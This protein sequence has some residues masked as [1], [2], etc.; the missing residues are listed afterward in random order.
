MSEHLATAARNVALD[1]L[2]GIG[3]AF[4][5]TSSWIGRVTRLNRLDAIALR[6]RAQRLDEM[7]ASL[8]QAP[9]L[10]VSAA[11]CRESAERCRAAANRIWPRP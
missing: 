9:E 3:A 10:Q 6:S 4:E 1:V 5:A 2:N 8:A 11:R 7:A